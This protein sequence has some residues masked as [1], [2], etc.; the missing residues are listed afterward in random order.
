MSPGNRKCRNL[1]FVGDAQCV[2]FEDLRVPHVQDGYW[3][4][5]LTNSVVN[6]KAAR[7]GWYHMGRWFF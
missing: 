7:M 6:L 4:V 5:I 2:V 3:W 1:P